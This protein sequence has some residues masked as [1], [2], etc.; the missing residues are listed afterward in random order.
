MKTMIILLTVNGLSDVNN[1]FVN[2]ANYIGRRNIKTDEFEDMPFI[3][4]FRILDEVNYKL[5]TEICE[6]CEEYH[7]IPLFIDI[8]NVED[9]SK[10]EILRFKL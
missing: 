3:K 9:I 5:S 1:A 7:V 6:I 10:M 8:E 2:I 4:G